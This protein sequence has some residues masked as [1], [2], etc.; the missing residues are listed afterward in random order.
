MLLGIDT[1]G[2]FTDAVLVRDDGGRESVVATAKSPTTHHA[3]ELGLAGAIDAVLAAASS[4]ASIGDID[5]VSVSTTL[6]TNAL[7]E[8][9]G[10]SAGLITLGFTEA[11]LGRAGLL[12]AVDEE[13]IVA[14]GGG[15]DAHGNER[16]PFPDDELR[17]AAATLGDRVAAFAVASQFSVR[18][19][20]HERAA[21]EAIRDVTG[22]PVTSSH[23]LSA[24]LDGPRRAL[25]AALNARLL[26]T[27][28][29][30][31]RAVRS[32]LDERSIDAPLMVVRGDGSLVS[33]DFAG[34][35]PI[36]TVLSGPAASV[37]GALHLGGTESG[38]VADIGGTTTDVA[39]VEDARPR[40]A[41]RGAV[42]GGYRTMVE[43]V[44]MAT[45][46]IG[47]D[48]EIRIDNRATGGPV[49]LG[50]E[51]AIP[52][53]RLVHRSPEIKDELERQL[54]APVGLT[55]HGRF[56]VATELPSSE[57]SDKRERQVL[58]RLSAGPR[59]EAEAAP[60]GLD[61]R[62]AARL[63][64]RGL[65][66][67]AT[68]TPTDAQAVLTG[69]DGIDR[70]TANL[71]ADVL[72]RQTSSKGGV[73]AEDGRAL[74][75][76]VVQRLVR[77]SAEFAL[78]VGLSADDIALES[79]DGLLAAALDH[80]RGAVDVGIRLGVPLVAIGAPAAVYYPDVAALVRTEAVVP[81]HAEVANAVGAVVGRVRV[82]HSCTVTQ[83]SKGQF[84][85]HLEEQPTFGSVENAR[86]AAL[87]LLEAAALVDAER[88]G[89]ADPELASDWSARTAWVEGK[90]VFV[91][92]TLTVEA[93]GRPRF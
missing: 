48:S 78:Q 2:T 5:L 47:G 62:A 67:V 27:I 35:R 6:A 3:L 70:A 4:D 24:R 7:V 19:P 37:I 53:G 40:I 86:A 57:L 84:R 82:R 16:Q 39:V 13:L 66:R 77:R 34:A 81:K 25:T 32:V 50:P 9:H 45:T 87:E 69:V 29:R 28:D 88:A 92:G 58:E 56:L 76:Q 51:R 43:A 14:L 68:F 12:D 17:A 75:E 93:S 54:S 85:V 31:N 38:L 60:S 36:E 18:N 33:S 30:L 52:L 91:E 42:V 55:S 26:G 65:V 63:R 49:L 23:E 1:G 73:I 74:A 80:H 21:A 83:P 8:G 10:E 64:A 61:G 72:A 59:T 22:K 20:G 46:G 44:D 90:E 79:G 11:E 71:A 15:H 89:A 41:P